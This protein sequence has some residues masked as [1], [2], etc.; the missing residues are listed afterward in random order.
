MTEYSPHLP[1]LRHQSE[2]LI[3]IR[4]AHVVICDRPGLERAACECYAAVRRRFERLLPSGGASETKVE[5]P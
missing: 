1:A 3:S 5:A 4:R 2:C